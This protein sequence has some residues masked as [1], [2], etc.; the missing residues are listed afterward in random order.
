MGGNGIAGQSGLSTWITYHRSKQRHGRAAGASTQGSGSASATES[1]A[2][3]FHS[4]R[5]GGP[6]SACRR[7]LAIRRRIAASRAARMIIAAQVVARDD[8][9]IE[10]SGDFRSWA[11]TFQ[12]LRDVRLEPG[13]RTKADVRP[14]LW[15]Y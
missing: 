7:P 2:T 14:R 8:E 3:S 6:L 5:R 1:R 9:V 12:T 10:Q 15:I 11:G 13:M 4:Q